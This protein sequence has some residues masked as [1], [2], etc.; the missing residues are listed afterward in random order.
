M[1]VQLAVHTILRKGDRMMR[2]KGD[3]KGQGRWA[4]SKRNALGVRRRR[5]Q[6]FLRSDY[7]TSGS[8][9]AELWSADEAKTLRA[10]HGLRSPLDVELNE[11]MLDVRFDGLGCDGKN[12]CNF[13][14]GSA[15]SYQI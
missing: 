8:L 4:S 7:R 13:L 11:D 12:S 5:R 14:V 10:R 3:A 6:K 1:C 2:R 15:L 9:E